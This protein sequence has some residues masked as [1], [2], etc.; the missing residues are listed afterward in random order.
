MKC[1]PA[2]AL[3]LASG[4]ALVGCQSAPESVEETSAAAPVIVNSYCPIGREEVD[5]S[6][7]TVTYKGVAVGFCCAGCQELWPTL[8]EAERDAFIAKARSGAEERVGG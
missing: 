5:P 8:S 1:M 3:V 7:E 2:M 4:F 6:V